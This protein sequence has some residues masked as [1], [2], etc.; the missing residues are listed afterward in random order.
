MGTNASGQRLVTDDLAAV[1]DRECTVLHVDMDAFFA[2]VELRRHPRLRG[3]PMMVAAE[4][5]RSVVL[6]ASYQARAFGVR[7]AMP[8]GRARSLCPEIAVVPPDPALYRQV[9]AQ[10]MD[11][12]KDVTPLTEPLSVDEAFLDVSGARRTAGRPGQIAV[13]L[14]NRIQRELDL[15]ATV[16]AAPTKFMAKLASSLA[17]P[18][19]L[20][21]VPADRTTD[22][23]HPLPVRALWG[24]GPA[25]ERV[26]A[27]L[28]LLTV[29]DVAATERDWL[30]RRLGAATGGR[31]HDLAWAK[32]ERAVVPDATE[33]SIGAETTFA[34]DT[35][36]TDL[37]GRELLGLADRTARRAR[38]TGVRGRT[39][40]IKIRSADFSTVTR[41]QT[42]AEPTDLARTIHRIALSLLGKVGDRGSVRLVGVRLESLV[43]AGEVSEQ[44]SFDAATDSPPGPGVGRSANAWRAAEGAVDQVSARFGASAIGPA[45]LAPSPASGGPHH[46]RRGSGSPLIDRTTSREPADGRGYLR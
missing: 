24:V 12:F 28:G 6:S 40:S 16:G 4:S 18:D 36:D 31:L 29:G 34:T 41:S 17:K 25:V 39:V 45:S 3:R 44:L 5:G 21:I 2:M 32:D 9:S 43:R 1:D 22:V 11:I 20:L 35:F 38:A 33:S 30:V 23:L 27:G 15:T 13:A 7:S 26:L 46:Q 10:V 19:G 14:R 37:I 42:L 8:V